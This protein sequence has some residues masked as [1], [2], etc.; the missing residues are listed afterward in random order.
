MM[1]MLLPQWRSLTPFALHPLTA[2]SLVHSIPGSSS[3]PSTASPVLP[4]QLHMRIQ[5]SQQPMYHHTSHS[6]QTRPYPSTS[7]A[8][9]A[10]GSSQMCHHPRQ[11]RQKLGI[12]RLLSE[13]MPAAASCQRYHHRSRAH[14]TP[15]RLLLTEATKGEGGFGSPRLMRRPYWATPPLLLL[16][17]RSKS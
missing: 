17:H 7:G 9:L 14:P 13:G 3:C 15:G 10:A 16:L 8:R 6:H 1:M 2:G 12:L 4:G 5:A 11:I